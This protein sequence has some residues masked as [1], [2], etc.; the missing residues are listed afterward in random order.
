MALAMAA[1]TLCRLDSLGIFVPKPRRSPPVMAA[2]RHP[3]AKRRKRIG[4]VHI[5]PSTDVSTVSS[6]TIA[7]VVGDN[8]DYQFQNG[9]SDWRLP[10]P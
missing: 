5:A 6:I 8:T 1:S 3:R 4:N 10:P 2:A 9:N 7:S